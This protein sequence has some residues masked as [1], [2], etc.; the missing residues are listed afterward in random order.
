MP[1]T[2]IRDVLS[3]ESVLRYSA[4]RVLKG[5]RP[6]TV[7]LRLGLRLILRPPPARDLTTAHDI[8]VSEIYDP[9]G[10]CGAGPGSLIVDV[11]GNVGYSSLYFAGQFPGSRILA[12]EPHPAFVELFDRHMA[13][14]GFTS[15]VTLVRAAAH[16]TAK[17]AILS[18]A[19]D[20]SSL[21]E[22]QER[23]TIPVQTV[24][25]F[26]AV[27]TGP[28]A[29]LKMDIEGGEVPL[30]ADARFALLDIHMLLL[31]WHDP[32]A[33]GTSKTWCIQRLAAL[34]YSIR[35][36]RQDRPTTGLITAGRSKPAVNHGLVRQAIHGAV[37]AGPAHAVCMPCTA[38][39]A[40]APHLPAI[41]AAAKGPRLERPLP[42]RDVVALLRPSRE[43]RAR[44]PFSSPASTGTTGPSS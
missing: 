42:H 28:V 44:Q 40:P 3:F 25:F 12:F 2:R 33:S 36:G 1:R 34:G 15:R 19:E 29:L 17:A 4:W 24:D 37:D 16:T 20:S 38:P 22:H 30:L 11:G 6:L 21:V 32:S 26:E 35:P 8:S 18:D 31:E 23:G 27:G 5:R 7:G 13:L 10:E 43:D 41:A 14:N 9:A 39:S